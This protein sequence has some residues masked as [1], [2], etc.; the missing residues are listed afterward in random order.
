MKWLGE[1]FIWARRVCESVDDRSLSWVISWKLTKNWFHVA[2]G[3]WNEKSLTLITLCCIA[4]SRTSFLKKILG[5]KITRNLGKIFIRALRLWVGRRWESILSYISKINRKRN[6]CSKGLIL[7]YHAESVSIFYHIGMT[8]GL[9]KYEKQWK[10][11][12]EFVIVFCCTS[13]SLKL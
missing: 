10:N 4:C 9:T 6:W 3:Y 11:S 7:K 8:R 5:F 13:Q 2:K 12:D 1:K